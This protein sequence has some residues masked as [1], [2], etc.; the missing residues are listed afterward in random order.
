MRSIFCFTSVSSILVDVDKDKTAKLTIYPVPVNSF[1]YLR[2]FVKVKRTHEASLIKCL[3]VSI[4][5]SLSSIIR[6]DVPFFVIAV[7]HDIQYYQH[8]H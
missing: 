6:P 8:Y 1:M 2:Q 7:V 5:P 3:L 4:K